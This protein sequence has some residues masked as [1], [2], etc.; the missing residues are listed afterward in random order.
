MSGVADNPLIPRHLGHRPALDGLRGVA[1]VLVL[2]HHT[3]AALLPWEQ[4]HILG[5]FLGVDVFFVLSGFLIT[6]ILLERR[7]DPERGSLRAFYRRRAARLL[8]ALVAFLAADLGLA[9]ALQRDLGREVRT[10]FAA[11][12]YTSNWQ[13]TFGWDLDPQNV[14]LWSLALEEQFYVVWPCVLLFVLVRLRPSRAMAATGAAVVAIACWRL[15]LG[16]HLGTAFH[17]VYYRTD[18]RLD[19][20]L[21]GAMVAL[22]V[23]Q[24]AFPAGARVVRWAA[25]AGAAVLFLCILNPKPFPRFMYGGGFTV[26]AVATAALV[27]SALDDHGPAARVL[28]WRPLAGLGRLSYSLYLFHVLAFALAIELVRGSTGIRVL[29]AYVLSLTFATVSYL[30]VERPLLRRYGD[31]PEAARAPEVDDRDRRR[32]VRPDGARARTP[33]LPVLLGSG[34]AVVGM[35][36]SAGAAGNVARRSADPVVAAAAPAAV[37]DTTP[38]SGPG[39]GQESPVTTADGPTPSPPATQETPASPGSLGPAAPAEPARTVLTVEIITR[40]V[41]PG[42][43]ERPLELVAHLRTSA[44]GA[45]ADQP[46]RFRL[47]LDGQTVECRSTTDDVGVARCAVAVDA[48]ATRVVVTARFDGSPELDPANAEQVVDL[49]GVSTVTSHPIAQ[50]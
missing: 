40:A 13:A 42:A 11:L 34:L 35:A 25:P 18:T 46:V 2:W 3:I 28:S 49:T 17:D 4:A 29:L 47:D 5:G 22:A 33:R 36:A 44:G 12:T 15:Y 31:R 10:A 45:V 27:F 41:E 43:L 24:H 20:L 50:I 48:T 1:I 7:A 9:L 38:P 19:S 23:Q 39:V 32:V 6:T 8:P 14:H 30:A 16:D 21:V 26:V 37:T